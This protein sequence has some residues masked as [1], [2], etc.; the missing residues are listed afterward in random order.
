MLLILF[1]IGI[2]GYMSVRNSGMQYPYRCRA[3]AGRAAGGPVD[4]LE[5]CSQELADQEE[6]DH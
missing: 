5:E 6:Q 2:G 1:S 4:N 3:P